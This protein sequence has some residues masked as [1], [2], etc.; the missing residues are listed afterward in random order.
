MRQSG[1]GAWGPALFS[2]DTACDVRGDYRELIE[3]G[4][5]DE[6][7]TRRILH[8]YESSLADSDDGPVVWLALAV[9]QSKL[10]RLDPTVR[11]HALEVIA[12]GTDLV[13]W[14]GDTNLLAKRQAALDK[15]RDQL[16]GPQPARKR[17]RPPKRHETTLTAGDV[18]TYRSEA[19]GEVALMRVQRIDAHRLSVAPI[20]RL[21]KFRGTSCPSDRKISK[22]KDWPEAPRSTRLQSP[23]PPWSSV[24]WRPTAHR[25]V[26]F[27]D[28][29]FRVVTN[30][31][32][33]SGDD[34]SKADSL[35]EW[36]M[37][38]AVLERNFRDG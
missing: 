11:D 27:A 6:D 7:A 24:T 8:R 32:T 14:Q 17:L 3:D 9:T 18:L 35:L 36:P 31:G 28:A 12:S 22:L 15:V 13:R 30:I 34:V 23:Q 19:A 26:D 21:L 1:M 10:G 33:R 38:A 20:L 5:D 37:L 2:D 29:G 4:V 16:L 25:G